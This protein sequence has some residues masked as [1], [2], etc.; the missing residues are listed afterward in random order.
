VGSAGVGFTVTE[1]YDWLEV[2]PTSGSVAPGANQTL[3]VKATC[4][5]IPGSDEGTVTLEFDHP[6]VS[7]KTV[8]VKLTCDAPV[9]L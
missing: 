8:L 6:A 1:D 2:S 4:P 9:I 5:S 7:A 3:G